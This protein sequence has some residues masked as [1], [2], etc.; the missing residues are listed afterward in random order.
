MPYHKCA[1]DIKEPCVWDHMT[2]KTAEPVEIDGQTLD[3]SGFIDSDRDCSVTYSFCTDGTLYFLM[4]D[5][6][7]IWSYRSDLQLTEPEQVAVM[8][9]TDTTPHF[10]WKLI[11]F[12]NMDEL[13][14]EGTIGSKKCFGSLNA[15]TGEM[16]WTECYDS[17]DAVVCNTG[18]MLYDEEAYLLGRESVVLYWEQGNVSRIPLKNS[19]ESDSFVYISP[20]GAYICTLMHGATQENRLI[21]RCSIYETKTGTFCRHFDWTFQSDADSNSGF[22]YLVID[23]ETQCVYL[24]NIDS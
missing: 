15:E 13:F 9:I 10:I 6:V 22:R 20:N 23:E 2:P 12:P 5:R 19:K 16:T 21:I 1:S 24:R 18:V 4:N 11:A 14:F 8:E 7:T 17:M 3:F